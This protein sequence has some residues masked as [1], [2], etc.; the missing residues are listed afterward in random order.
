[1]ARIGGTGPNLAI[2][3]WCH[4]VIP[5]P[6]LDLLRTNEQATVAIKNL[7]DDTMG[8][9][10]IAERYDANQIL[11]PSLIIKKLTEALIS[12]LRKNGPGSITSVSS[13][14]NLV[15]NIPESNLYKTDATVKLALESVIVGAFWHYVPVEGFID[16]PAKLLA[17]WKNFEHERTHWWRAKRAAETDEHT[18][19]KWDTL[20]ADLPHLLDFHNCLLHAKELAEKPT[21]KH[22]CHVSSLTAEGRIY[23]N[24]QGRSISSECRHIMVRTFCNIPIKSRPERKSAEP[25]DPSEKRERKKR[26]RVQIR[27]DFDDDSPYDAGNP[28]LIDTGGEKR[29]RRNAAR[30]AVANIGAQAAYLLPS[31]GL[32]EENSFM[33]YSGDN[34]VGV[35]SYVGV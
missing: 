3:D 20:L 28:A 25:A 26:E 17:T 13:A 8:K 33:G 10:R 12:E 18:R 7:V 19:A 21:L 35:F 4:V 23:E 6:S 34:H 9:H 16:S 22:T 32:F 31:S 14:I 24:G 15:A 2:P 11:G 29:P 1:M 27:M 5:T 30:L